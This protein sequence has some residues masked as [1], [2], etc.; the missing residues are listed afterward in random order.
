MMNPGRRTASASG[1][2]VVFLIGMRINQPLKVH[3]WGP[4]F[5]SMGAMLN[6]LYAKPEL[7]LL[8]HETWFART[9][10]M[11]QYWKSMDQ[12]LAYAKA[13]DSAHLPAWRDFNKKVSASGAVGVWHET[14]SAGPK[15]H[16][17]VYVNM[18]DFGLG[19]ALGSEPVSAR[20][21]SAGLRL[22]RPAD[23]Q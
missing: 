20:R 16:E 5:N 12:L 22:G 17:A 9:T 19:K 10:L 4:V 21:D 8:S 2:F 14:Y 6:E 1:D 18:P 7:G 23:S 15:T 13:R 11:V 3:K